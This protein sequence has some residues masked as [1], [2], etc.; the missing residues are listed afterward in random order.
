MITLSVC[1][2]EVFVWNASDWLELRENHRIVGNLIGCLPSLPRQDSFRGLPLVLL[3]EEATLL[4]EK[5]IAKLVSYTSVSEQNAIKA[6]ENFNAYKEKIKQ[7]QIAYYEEERKKQVESMIDRIIEGKRRK[8]SSLKGKKDQDNSSG[9]KTE[10]GID[11]E[12]IL[13]GELEKA[14]NIPMT[15]TLVQTFTGDVWSTDSVN[16]YVEW[17]F[18]KRKEEKLR[19]LT[20]KDLW[21]KGYYIT[22]GQKFGGDFLVYPGDPVKFHAQFIVVCLDMQT[23]LTASDIITYGRLGSSTR[24]TVAI[25]SLE[26]NS[27][28]TYQ[29]LSWAEMN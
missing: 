29:S 26:R 20:F 27:S 12:A 25:A 2:G 28:I 17:T 7:E 6:K 21:E 11:R 24:K 1:N 19:Y 4:I 23:K 8:F 14:S 3:P 10:L 16:D 15:N 18:P 9:N 5:N 22:S 13:K